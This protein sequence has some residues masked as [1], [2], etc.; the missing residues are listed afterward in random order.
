MSEIKKLSKKE[1]KWLCNK[2]MYDSFPA[3]EIKSYRRVRRGVREGWYYGYGLYINGVLSGYAL[4]C[5][6]E[7]VSL[8]DY[9]A[10]NKSLRGTGLGQ[11]MMRFLTENEPPLVIE[12]DDPDFAPD[13]KEKK[14]RD[15]R[16]HFYV[17]KCACVNNGI[18]ASV[19]DCPFV[20]LSTK[21]PIT[22]EDYIG[23]YT[24]MVP[25]FIRKDAVKV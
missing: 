5:N 22:G 11:E 1:I 18:K 13:E 12:A 16:I 24:K 14:V 4:I 21:A 15:N 8:L 7:T 10:V 25:E 6:D 20:L 19:F 3:N 9:L 2:G 23:L 17:D